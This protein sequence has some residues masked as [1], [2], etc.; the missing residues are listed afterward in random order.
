MG[1]VSFPRQHHRVYTMV[2][3]LVLG[4]LHIP[5]RMPDIPPKFKKLLVSMASWSDWCLSP[6][7]HCCSTL[8]SPSPSLHGPS[9][10]YDGREKF[11]HVICVGNCCTKEMYEFLRGLGKEIHIVRGDFDE[12]RQ[13]HAQRPVVDASS[14]E[15]KR[16]GLLL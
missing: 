16:S 12:V 7:V 9:Y 14:R 6:A 11:V 8:T 4:D 10:Q 2:M 1:S 13:E 5:H 15:A 3:A